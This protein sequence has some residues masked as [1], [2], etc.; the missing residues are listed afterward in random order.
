MNQI[1]L[2]ALVLVGICST[3]MAKAIIEPSLKL[4]LQLFPV[5][6]QT[7]NVLEKVY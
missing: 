5:D 2:N 4:K 3:E 6:E 7:L 1:C